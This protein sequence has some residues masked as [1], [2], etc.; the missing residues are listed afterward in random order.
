MLRKT[1]AWL[2]RRAG[3]PD[4]IYWMCLVSFAESSFFLIPPDVLLVPMSLQR[5]DRMWWYSCACSLASII[6]GIFG[7][8]VGFYLFE[9]VGWKIIQLYN[10]EQSFQN[11]QEAF[12]LYGPWF[13]ILK[14]V[15]PIPYKL[16][17]ITAG[18]A[19][20]DLTI[21]FVCSIVARFSRYFMITAL[22]HYY[23]EQVERIIERRLMTVT[24][25]LL[26]II[27]GGI[28]S[29]KAF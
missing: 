27:F 10:A 23:G 8:A 17:A 14:G 19:K 3:M 18:F 24:T 16:L 22:L 5:R 9:S 20:L 2:V 12:A 15:T 21:F 28:L 7:Y 25:I 29:F 6:G 26:I 1:Y 4:A 13:L 11:F